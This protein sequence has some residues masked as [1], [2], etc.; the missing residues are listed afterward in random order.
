MLPILYWSFLTVGD[1]ALEKEICAKTKMLRF[2]VC[3]YFLLSKGMA[4][5]KVN[6]L[7]YKEMIG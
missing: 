1:S 4:W 3:L 6:I 5:K 2:D 7:A